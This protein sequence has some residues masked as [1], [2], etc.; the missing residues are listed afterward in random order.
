[1]SFDHTT[2]EAHI[3]QLTVVIRYIEKNSP[4]ERF[5]AFMPNRGLTGAVMANALLEF[6]SFIIWQFL[7]HVLDI[8]LI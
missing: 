5:L 8:L 2:D 7:C 3:D 1:M 4:K 6:L